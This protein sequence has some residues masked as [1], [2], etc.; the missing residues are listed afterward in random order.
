MVEKLK[1]QRSNLSQEGVLIFHLLEHLL[2][3]HLSD[4]FIP[5]RTPS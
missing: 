3:E 5:V 1:E 4:D 2:H